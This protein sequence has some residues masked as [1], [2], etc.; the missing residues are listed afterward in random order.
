MKCKLLLTKWCLGMC[1]F[2]SSMLIEVFWFGNGMP[3]PFS[4]FLLFPEYVHTYL[5][6]PFADFSFLSLLFPPSF[7]RP[8]GFFLLYSPC[9][10]LSISPA[11][12]PPLALLQA[13]SRP[14]PLIFFPF[15]CHLK[16]SRYHTTFPVHLYSRERSI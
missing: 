14:T 6:S 15:C 11:S 16:D 1:D 9:L 4:F 10:C 13:G 5:V 8:Y 2:I 3:F 12:D 7:I